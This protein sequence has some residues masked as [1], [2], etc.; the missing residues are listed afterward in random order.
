M[1]HVGMNISEKRTLARELY[2]VIRPGGRI[3]IYDVMKVSE[4]EVNF[5]VPWAAGPDG[6]FLATAPQYKAALKNAGF[7]IAS[8]RNRRDFALN[9]FSQMQSRA[10]DAGAPPPLGLHILMGGTAALKIKNMIENISRNLLAPVEIIADKPGE[11][12]LRSK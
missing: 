3:G 11:S 8:E 5:P 2:R 4:G 10:D 7:R 1:L 6:S 9:F 12:L